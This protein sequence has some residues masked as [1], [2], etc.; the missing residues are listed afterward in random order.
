MHFEAFQ[1]DERQI[2]YKFV[3]K[4]KCIC[5]DS[6]YCKIGEY[7]PVGY[8]TDECP[9]GY[10]EMPSLCEYLSKTPID[11][12]LEPYDDHG[13]PAFHN[14]EDPSSIA[15]GTINK[16]KDLQDEWIIDLATPCYKGYCGQDYDEFVH[17]YNPLADSHDYEAIGDPAG[18]TFGCDLWVEVTNIY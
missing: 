8:A 6:A 9:Q 5:V 16:K 11:G 17:R 12:D 10:E 14:P 13:V 4:P 15:T 2:D 1:G 18:T 3:Q 7:A